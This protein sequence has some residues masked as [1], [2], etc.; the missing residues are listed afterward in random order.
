ELLELAAS[1]QRELQSWCDPKP[2]RPHL[3]LARRRAEC[4]RFVPADVSREWLVTEFE[5]I[6]SELRSAG[7][8][9][10]TLQCFDLTSS[11]NTT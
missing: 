10:Q 7:P 5:L 1:L 6:R 8:E 2:F 9:Y 11:G 4:A 3:T